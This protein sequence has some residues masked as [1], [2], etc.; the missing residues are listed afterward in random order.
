MI[1][2]GIHQ[3]LHWLC[4]GIII[5]VFILIQQSKGLDL[6][7]I[8]TAMAAFG[9][10]IIVL[11]IPTG[12]LA[13][14]H[15]RKRIYLIATAIYLLSMILLIF[16]SSFITVVAVLIVYA[17]SKALN[18]GSMAAW[19]VDEFHRAEPEGNL[20]KALAINEIIIL[21][22]LGLGSIIGGILP[23]TIGILLEPMRFLDEYSANLIAIMIILVLLM[24]YT[25]FFIH[26]DRV[27]LS[28]KKSLSQQ[29][30]SSM[31]F[32]FSHRTI[33]LLL[34]ATFSLGIGLSTLENLWQPR[35]AQIGSESMDSWIFGALSAGY[36]ISA[37]VGSAL[38]IPIARKASGRFPL[39]L[40]V[41]MALF[42]LG[43]IF[44]ARQQGIPG[45]AFWYILLF[46]FNGASSS[47]HDT[48]LNDQVP[49]ERRSTILSLSSF[50]LQL[51][52]VLGS[53]AGGLIA[54]YYGI[55]T[56]WTITGILLILS[57][58]LYLGIKT[59]KV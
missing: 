41:N 19:F 22:A 15:G 54:E 48:L 10:T 51:G 46:S 20:Q 59:E 26:E 29:L 58:L 33:L 28:E 45:F 57:G 34:I 49:S 39:L 52:G 50:A 24:I 8:G 3:T 44:L 12:S 47:P 14:I 55:P 2:Y 7:Q 37:A 16:A 18:S 13:D 11:E 53:L 9:T 30:I 17:V 43:Y 32:G 38:M 56:T 40:A 42:G 4:L 31:R 27:G 36:F 6:L 5:P 21:I 1:R 23:D 25:V 35:V